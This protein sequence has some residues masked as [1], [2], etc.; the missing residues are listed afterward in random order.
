MVDGMRSSGF[1]IDPMRGKFI[2]LYGSNNLGKSAQ[3]ELLENLWN[4][5]ERP[6]RRIKYPVYSLEPTGPRI[7]AV[8]REG[9]EIKEEE[10]QAEFAQNRKD[11][12]PTLEEILEKGI[13]VIAWGLV[14]GVEREFLDMV[15]AGLLEPD[16]A[17]CLDGERF[18]A[19][20]ERGHRHEAAG[21]EVW[22]KSRRI[23]LEL[24]REFG[25]DIVDAN[26]SMDKV[27]QKIVDILLDKGA[28]HIG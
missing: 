13:D 26:Q 6:Y 8:L 1:M 14:K 27:H 25:W 9:L 11:F 18:S 4:E 5:L 15:N 28:L 21:N 10:L 20:I 16:V 22:E 7:N 24:A 23:H 3:L 19:S 17:I 2:V 12:Q